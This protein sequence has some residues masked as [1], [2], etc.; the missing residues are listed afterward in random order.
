M[1]L[2]LKPMLKGSQTLVAPAVLTSIAILSRILFQLLL[3]L[4]ARRE[5]AAQVHVRTHVLR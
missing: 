3:S 5:T 1:L 4:W 2:L